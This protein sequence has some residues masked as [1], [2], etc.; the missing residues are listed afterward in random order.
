MSE[1][2]LYSNRK[3]CT[4]LA[5][6]D[7]ERAEDGV[8]HEPQNV[9]VLK[10]MLEEKLQ[11]EQTWI[12]YRRVVAEFTSAVKNRTPKE[13]AVALALA[14]VLFLLYYSQA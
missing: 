2:P 8:Q 3:K 4:W 9:N 11:A 7:I 6:Y 13:A 14:P 1:V 10:M 5:G 12:L